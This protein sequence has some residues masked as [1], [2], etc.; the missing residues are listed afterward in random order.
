LTVLLLLIS[1]VD[2]CD[3]LK[4]FSRP[5]FYGPSVAVLSSSSVINIVNGH[6]MSTS[7]SNEEKHQEGRRDDDNKL[8]DNI[9][10][11]SSDFWFGLT[12]LHN[13]YL[14]LGWGNARA[15]TL[16]CLPLILYFVT[17]IALFPS[18]TEQT[19]LA[20]ARFL[21][22]LGA[23]AIKLYQFPM[24]IVL[25]SLSFLA[26]MSI[27]A[28]MAIKKKRNPIQVLWFV[29]R[30]IAKG[31]YKYVQFAEN[32]SVIDSDLV[33]PVFE[34][35]LYR[36]LFDR[37]WHG[38]S[39]LI[40]R[41]KTHISKSTHGSQGTKI[42]RSDMADELSLPQRLWFGCEPW[43]LVSSLFFAAATHLNNWWPTTEACLRS[44]F[45]EHY[46]P[47]M[48]KSDPHLWMNFRNFI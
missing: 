7:T 41:L 35:I 17:G 31:E 4:H 11:W 9:K 46:R 5:Q 20:L 45:I 2:V 6:R 24:V 12:H 36:C 28:A 25:R 30:K 43:V 14:D 37:V 16:T 47:E 32:S 27:I 33:A 23:H 8:T 39:R 22:I 44:R 18:I 29:L 3:G 48:L 38:S 15:V 1:S 26:N 42:E 19:R 40:T 13:H 10:T 21:S 34:E